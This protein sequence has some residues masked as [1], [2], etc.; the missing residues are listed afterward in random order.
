MLVDGEQVLPE[1]TD[2]HRA[3]R[4]RAADRGPEA[5][6]WTGSPTTIST[7]RCRRSSPTT[8]ARTD[9]SRPVRRRGG[10][11]AARRGLR[12]VRRA[13]ATAGSGSRARLSR[14]PTARP[15]LCS[16]IAAPS[17]PGATY[18]ELSRYF[19]ATLARPSFSRVV[20]EARPYRPIFPPGLR[21]R[22]RRLKQETPPL[23]GGVLPGHRQARP[24]NLS[25]FAR[26]GASAL[27]RAA[28]AVGV[29]DRLGAVA[30]AGLGEDAVDVGLDGRAGEDQRVGD[31]GVGEPAAISVS[32][33]ASRAVRSSAPVGR[34]LGVA[35]AP[36]VGR[37]LDQPALDRGVEVGLPGVQ[38][39]GSRARSPRRRRP[40]SG[41]RGRRRAARAAASR[42]RR[43]SSGR[44]R[45]RRRHAARRLGAVAP[46]SAGPSAR[47]RAR[48]RRASRT[49]CS[50]SSAV[51]DHLDAVEHPDDHRQPVAHHPLVV[52]DQDADHCRNSSSTR[53][54]SPP[55]RPT[56]LPPA[57]APA[58]ASP[59]A[60]TRHRRH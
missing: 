51:A 37:E 21:R 20:E 8:C 52:G 16:S 34:R 35:G 58:P 40:W 55:V 30:D 56:T 38:R 54:P 49:A 41:S 53:N 47:R 60:P 48:A 7:A 22:L 32:T 19:R 26:V 14:S 57:C 33:S 25:E 50:P 36:R 28:G 2:D 45:R 9:S 3:H 1:S 44:A 23:R 27:S 6:L 24:G 15:R 31:L 17:I 4:R 10:P 29:R 5:R 42:R 43:R 12:R 59:P 13:P 18:P 46:A 11:R 39:R